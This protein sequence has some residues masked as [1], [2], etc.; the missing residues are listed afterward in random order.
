MEDVGSKSN[1]SPILKL[2]VSRLDE[3]VGPNSG[4]I[5]SEVS[6]AQRAAFRSTSRGRKLS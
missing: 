2:F 5:A 1:A 3:L 4:S 6:L